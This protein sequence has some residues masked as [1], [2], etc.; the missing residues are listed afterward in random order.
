VTLADSVLAAAPDTVL[1]VPRGTL[2]PGWNNFI[3]FLIVVALSGLF[4]MIW[5]A[6]TDRRP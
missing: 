2:G 3:A 5:R 6:I 4:V 1:D